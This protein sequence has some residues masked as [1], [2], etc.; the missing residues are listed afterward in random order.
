MEAIYRLEYHII[1]IINPTDILYRMRKH[2]Q[3]YSQCFHRIKHY[4]PIL[5]HAFLSTSLSFSSSL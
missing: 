5:F 2:H 1:R 4:V 3:P